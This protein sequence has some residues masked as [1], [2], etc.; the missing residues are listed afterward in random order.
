MKDMNDAPSETCAYCRFHIWSD[1]NRYHVCQLKDDEEKCPFE[2]TCKSFKS[3][4]G[5]Y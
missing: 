3:S 4:R 5:A 2:N 1:K